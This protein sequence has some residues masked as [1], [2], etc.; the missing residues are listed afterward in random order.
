MDAEARRPVA[1]ATAAERHQRNG[2]GLPSS[3]CPHSL[4][5][6]NLK[7]DFTAFNKAIAQKIQLSKTSVPDILADAAMKIL[8]GSGSAPGLT[9]L[10]RKATIE[11]IKSDMK[12]MVMGRTNAGKMLKSGKRQSGRPQMR[13]RLTWLA[14]RWLKTRG[15]PKTKDLV[16]KAMAAILAARIKSR[17]YIAAGWLFCARSLLIGNPGLQKKHKLTRLKDSNIPTREDAT[18][19][20]SFATPIRIQGN[21]AS[22]VLHNTSRGGETVGMEN[23]QQAINNATKDVQ[24]YSDN[25]V[26]KEVLKQMFQGTNFSVRG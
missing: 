12:V 5:A 13:S 8:I 15:E 17:A 23:V 2:I 19:A 22:L 24:L 1:Y 4:R 18:A 3:P 11:R 20:N 7:Y 10:T 25:E 14:L 26:A 9:K 21:T 16:R 6:V